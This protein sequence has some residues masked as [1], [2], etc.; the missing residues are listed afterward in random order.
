MFSPATFTFLDELAANNER[1]WFAA[2]RERYEALVRAP[3]L[4][5]IAA[6]A[7]ALAGFAPQYRADPR[8]T[9]G[10]L[11]RMHRDTRFSRDKRPYKTNVG[12]QFR[13]ELGTDVHAA[14]FYMHLANDGC[15][16]AAG[17]WHPDP[18]TLTGIRARI[19]DHPLLWFAVRDDPLFT[20]NWT[21]AGDSLRRPPRGY[22]ADHPAIDDIR[23]KD[24]IGMAP[25]S[26]AEATAGGL[27]SLAAQ[28]FAAAM[29]L[30][31]FLCHEAY[32]HHT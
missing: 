4:A 16:F 20:A 22:A 8:P 6:M 15:F 5:F 27:V 1:S 2:N 23:R 29:P 17:C 18:G 14:A 12:I 25:L 7:P 32:R 21:L 13:H 9:G 3:A 28:R 24:F 19:A 31:D 10:S 26:F 11:M 30:L